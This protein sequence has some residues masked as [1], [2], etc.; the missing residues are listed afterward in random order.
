MHLD[1]FFVIDKDWH[2]EKF[3]RVDVNQVSHLHSLALF[4]DVTSDNQYITIKI[5]D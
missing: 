1:L 3:R 4:D 2:L 5:N